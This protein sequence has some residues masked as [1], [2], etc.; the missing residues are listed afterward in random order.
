MMGNNSVVFKSKLRGDL[1]VH[2]PL[3]F[4]ERVI[5]SPGTMHTTILIKNVID[6]NFNVRG[7][8]THQHTPHGM[9]LVAL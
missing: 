5:S 6:V 4:T 7:H 8:F 9:G 2:V 1:I 3:I